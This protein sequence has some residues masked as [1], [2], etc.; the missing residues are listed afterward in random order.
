MGENINHMPKKLARESSSKTVSSLEEL[1]LPHDLARRAPKKRGRS[2]PPA[3]RRVASPKASSSPPVP[4]A[5]AL[6][7]GGWERPMQSGEANS[8]AARST[9]P[10]CRVFD[11]FLQGVNGR[12]PEVARSV[13]LPIG[14]GKE[15]SQA[16]SMAFSRQP[17]PGSGLPLLSGPDSP[18]ERPQA[19]DELTLFSLF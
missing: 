14:L 6:A 10:K 18:A 3:R 8:R 16:I 9:S 13:A 7:S 11:Q 4:K 17:K 2:L 5:F 19:I 15:L 12:T 1:T